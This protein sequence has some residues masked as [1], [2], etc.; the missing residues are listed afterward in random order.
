MIERLVLNP[1]WHGGSVAGNFATVA[2]IWLHYLAL[3]VY[4]ATLSADYSYNAFPV[5][6]SF[7]EPEVLSA[8]AIIAS[9][10]AAAW[11]L[12]R[13]RPL[14]GYGAL[15]MLIAILP[16]SHLIPIKEIM[17]EHY[18]YVPLF[19]FAL[20]CG[21]LF[22]AAC[23]AVAESGVWRGRA[24]VVYGLVVVLLM[25]AGVRVV[26]RNRDWADEE[27]LWTVT[28][29]AMP[30]CARA[31]YNLAGIHL[32]QKRVGDAQREFATVL[33]ISPNHADAL[34]GLGEIAFQQKRYGQALG[35]ANQAALI[36]P[37]SFR[38]KYLLGWIHLA[39]KKLDK[40]ETYFRQAMKLKPTY[41]LIYAGLEAVAKE[42]GD[43]EAAAQWAEKQRSLSRRQAAPS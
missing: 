36:N 5:S 14:I 29:Q 38:I 7:L 9:V 27:T 10:T 30:R 31:H 3:L 33:A 15:W 42:R 11:A 21:L 16:V 25:L 39:V 1:H 18:L 32:R 24:L 43:T 20:I 41:A 2:R 4:P 17:A 22:D 40:A 35:Y 23:G 19:G 26:A 28:A 13:W 8:L 34:A 37:R 12:S 6:Q